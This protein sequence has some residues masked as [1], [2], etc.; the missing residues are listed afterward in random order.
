[1][2][3]LPTARTKPRRQPDAMI[4]DANASI[5][6]VLRMVR[7]GKVRA[8]QGHDVAIRAD[9]VCIHGDGAHALEFAQRLHT[10]LHE[11]GVQVQAG[12]TPSR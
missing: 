9:T 5:A 8:Q 6:Q 11:A 3:Y 12:V 4:T 2:R 7:E 10:A 1:M